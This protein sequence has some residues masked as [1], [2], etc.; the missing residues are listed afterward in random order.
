VS[1]RALGAV[2]VAGAAAAWLTAARRSGT[3]PG[4]RDRA[5]TRIHPEDRD[6]DSFSGRKQLI[7]AGGRQVACVEAGSGEPLVLL[8]GCPFHAY[9][10]RDVIPILAER[11][12]VIAP[13]LLGLGDTPVS[14]ADDYR[15]PRDA[16]MVCDLLDALGLESAHFVGHDHGGATCLLLMGRSPERMR[17]VV[18]T[19]VEAYDDWPSADET[20][21]LHLIVRTA[22]TP[23]LWELM[24][25]PFFRRWAFSIAAHRRE[26]L[27]DATLDAIVAPLIATPARWQRL[28]RFFAGQLDPEHQAETVRAVEGMRQFTAPTLLLWGRRDGNFGEPVARKLLGDI[29]GA[30]RIEWMEE[31]GH[32]PMLEEPVAYAAAVSDFASAAASSTLSNAR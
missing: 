24:H 31:S 30:D 5:T 17:S 4:P 15:L 10:W 20:P 18:L 23:I 29:P 6:R 3:V 22:T 8:H 9:E 7:A 27:T 19:N 12:R 13:D 21:F 28:R 1:G 25:S 11:Y 32:L 26:A 2:A 14:L 16:E